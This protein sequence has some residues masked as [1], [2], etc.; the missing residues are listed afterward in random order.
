LFVV[1]IPN[2]LLVDFGDND[3]LISLCIAEHAAVQ[4]H[5]PGIVVLQVSHL[6]CVGTHVALGLRFQCSQVYRALSAAGSQEP[7][8]HTQYEHSSQSEALLDALLFEKTGWQ[9]KRLPL[10]RKGTDS[11]TRIK[12]RTD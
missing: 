1:L 8:E 4:G 5:L 7:N 6:A 12:R 2:P 10:R 9:I 11:P 3:I